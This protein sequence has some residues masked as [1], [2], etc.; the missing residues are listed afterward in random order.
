VRIA[1][2]GPAAAADAE[3]AQQALD[4]AGIELVVDRAGG[5]PVPDELLERR[6]LLEQPFAFNRSSAA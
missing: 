3:P 4:A 2:P 6:L 5:E 1:S